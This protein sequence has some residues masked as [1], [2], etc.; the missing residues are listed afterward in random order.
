MGE[1]TTRSGTDRTRFVCGEYW[2]SS[3]IGW[4]C[5]TA[6]GVTARSEPTD[7][8]PGR[9]TAGIAP[10]WRRSS[11]RWRAPRVSDR[12]PVVHARSSGAGLPTRTWVGA[13]VSATR[14]TAKRARSAVNSPTSARSTIR[15]RVALQATVDADPLARDVPGQAG[16]EEEYGAGHIVGSAHAS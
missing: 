1:A 7:R 6:P 16:D 11:R 4:R 9:A 12:P 10:L 2:I 15:Y 8:M 5:T 14:P 3:Y 13:S